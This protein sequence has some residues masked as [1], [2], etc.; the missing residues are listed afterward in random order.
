MP[1][2]DTYFFIDHIKCGKSVLEIGTGAGEVAMH[3]A[4]LG[5][6]VTATDINGNSLKLAKSNAGNL[7]IKFIKSDLFENISGKFD[8]ILFNPPYLPG[9]YKEDPA[10]YGGKS[11]SDIIDIFLAEAKK[12]LN[13]E[14]EIYVILSSYNDIEMLIKKHNYYSF[15][16]IATLNL[17]FHQIFC[18]KLKKTKSYDSITNIDERT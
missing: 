15:E 6:K 11:G 8:T 12:H 7:K 3:C 14:G 5:S 4:K 10:I 18:Y 13:P 9:E 1:S 2:E 16:K 17:A